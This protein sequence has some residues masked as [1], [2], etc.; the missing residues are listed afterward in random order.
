MAYSLAVRSLAVA[1][2][3]LAWAS[4]LS[5]GDWPMWRCDAGRTAS[6]PD[7]LPD[8]L[9]PLWKRQF[10]PRKTVWDD[11]LN[12]DLM[13]YDKAF[14]PIVAGKRLFLGFNDADKVVAID[15]SSG[16]ILWTFYTDG[17]VRFPPVAHKDS[18]YFTS[19]DGHLYCVRQ[20]DGELIWRHRGGPSERLI[21]GNERLISTW[22]A[23][24]GPV[25]MDDTVYFAASIWPFMGTF[26]YALD[27][28]TGEVRWLNDASASTYIDQPHNSPAF[29]GV[30]PQGALVASGQI[31]L[32]PGGRSIPAAFDRLN[33]K[34]LYFHLAKY[35]KSGGSHAMAAGDYFF[36]HERDKKYSIYDLLTGEKAFDDQ[37]GQP[38]ITA[39]RVYASGDSVAA[40]NYENLKPAKSKPS[41]SLIDKAKS[42]LSSVTGDDDDDD[43]D[44]QEKPAENEKKDDKPEDK[45]DDKKD[46]KAKHEPVWKLKLDANADMVIAGRRLYAA[47]KSVITVIE[48]SEDGATAKID[49]TINVPGTI[50]RIIAADDKLFVVTAEGAIHAYGAGSPAEPVGEAAPAAADQ[51]A[52]AAA[53]AQAKLILDRTRVTDGYGLVF[54]V[55]NGDLLQALLDGST[56]RLIAFD[57]DPAT[58]QRARKRFDAAGLYGKRI[59]VHVGTPRDLYLPPYLA[60]LVIVADPQSAGLT[61]SADFL[62]PIFESLRPYGG[63]AWLPMSESEQ[64]AFLLEMPTD[65]KFPQATWKQAA[66]AIVLERPGALPGSST[67][68]HIYGN[69]ANTIKSDDQLVKLPLGLLWFGGS[70]NM[71]VLPRHGHG[72]PEQVIGGRLFIQGMESLSA[73][74]VY[75]GRV[76]WK[77]ELPRLGNFG[78]FYD[79]TYKDTPLSTAYN[80]V[81]IPGANARG[82]NFVATSD[83]VYILQAAE[84]TVLDAATGKTLGVFT[85]GGKKG[86]AATKSDPETDWA[87]IGIHENLL[88]G[89]DGFASYGETP[90][91]KDKKSAWRFQDYERVAS[92]AIVVLDRLSGEEIWRI[93]AKHGFLHNGITAGDGTLYVLDKA[94]PY[95]EQKLKRQ[96]KPP[97]AGTRLLA[98]DLNTGTIKWEEN[99]DVFGS[100]LSYSPEHKVVLQATRP[101]RDMTLGEE[102]KRMIVYDA[103]SGRVKW[104]KEVVYTDPPIL[105]GDRILA[106]GRGFALLTGDTVMRD[107]PL[108][109]KPIPWTYARSYGCNYPIAAENLLTFRSAAAGFYDLVNEGGVGNFGGFK[110]SCSSNLVAADGVLNAPDYTRT[111]T[112][113]YQNQT[114]LAFVHMPELEM[115][116]RNDYAYRGGTVDRIGVNLGAPGDR[117]SS[118]GTLWLEHPSRGAPSP[119]VPIELTGTVKYFQQHSGRIENSAMPW[120]AASGVEGEATIRVTL[121]RDG[122]PTLEEGLP[123]ASSADD[124]EEDRLGKV[125]IDS[126][127][128]ELVTDKD[129]Q[130]VGLRFSEL[131]IPPGAEIASAHIQFSAEE[132]N[133]R[134]A[135]LVIHAEEVDNAS[136]FTTADGNVSGRTR[137]AASVDWKPGP[138]KKGTK[139][140]S[141]DLKSLVSAI[142]GRP[143]WKSGSAM[144]F[145]ITGRGKRLAKSF[146]GGA[147]SA[148]RLVVKL[149]GQ[150]QPAAR[151]GAPRYT[152]RLH[153]AEPEPLPPG[154]R[155][156]DVYVQGHKVLDSFDVAVAAGGAQ[157]GVIREIPGVAVSEAL[158]VELKAVTSRPPILCGVEAVREP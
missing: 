73:R 91:T 38:V 80:Q 77:A 71:D 124:A 119:K 97:L 87:Y 54:G 104:N 84:C 107:D 150:S 154:G 100:W 101:S 48:E 74:D 10:T 59:S 138:W 27:A 146:D 18:V 85:L 51:T 140:N 57:A 13:P 40:Y 155:V 1:F 141:P 118:D 114:S 92:R 32:V 17:P 137:T 108:T 94:P 3:T 128:L 55:G 82:T 62:K 33:G 109:G 158:T 15:T 47:G 69:L 121:N 46:D 103:K 14:E 4:S 12:Q 111:C 56:L 123:I 144:S 63:K 156:F 139:E 113:S 44:L 90:K 67:W 30:A 110:S 60:S 88:I 34:Q 120:V 24:G 93:N 102:G 53:N 58:V 133:D 75:T 6:S 116:T 79:E 37:L 45:K 148:P 16:L 8:K 43:H 96:G 76:I 157:R 89:G 99:K 143:G 70:S 39:K 83:R 11:P 129:R 52:V 86:T 81:H 105:H 115:W 72:P 66:G 126:S 61:A 7:A 131:S 95:V 151:D 117:R 125:R 2:A 28:E 152:I 20:S 29:A 98:L 50:E 19:D 25:V 64:A 135:D 153:F 35:N 106:G 22:P 31:L 127:D 21:L 136:P 122:D 42:A 145:I 9:H 49:G 112:C 5:A 41:K 147:G 26:I 132:D 130:I 134:Q 36:G 65:A 68:T 78:V 142:V 149:A 23:R